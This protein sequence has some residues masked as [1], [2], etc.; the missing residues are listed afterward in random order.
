MKFVLFLR[1]NPSAE[2]GA[3]PSQ[4]GHAALIKFAQDLVAAGV[5]VDAVGLYP[6][7]AATR[8]TLSTSPGGTDKQIA[9]TKGPFPVTEVVGAWWVINVED[10][11]EAIE[12][13]KKC[14]APVV[15]DSQVVEIRRIFATDDLPSEEFTEEMKAETKRIRAGLGLGP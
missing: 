12:W 11:E 4:D 6:S 2:A 1:S 15:G 13:G 5:L 8:I 3:M 7:Q 10:E 14:P 9:V